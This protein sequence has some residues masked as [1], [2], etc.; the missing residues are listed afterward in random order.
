MVNRGRRL[1][2]SQFLIVLLLPVAYRS[3]QVPVKDKP[4]SI[5]AFERQSTTT[6]KGMVHD[7]SRF[8]ARCRKKETVHEVFPY[9]KSD[10]GTRLR[11]CT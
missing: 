8:N 1:N 2:D 4:T 5:Y 3:R 6:V 9:Q 10:C 7:T 11:N